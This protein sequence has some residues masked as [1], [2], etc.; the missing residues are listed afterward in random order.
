MSQIQT[1]R[2]DPSSVLDY[3]I[4][5]SEWLATGE[6]IST[7]TWTVPTGI[8]EDSSSKS[9]TSTLIWLSGGTAGNVYELTNKIVTTGGRTCERSIMIIVEER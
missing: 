4:D 2:K 9:D 6:T 7:S 3:G 8:T 1:F 5:W